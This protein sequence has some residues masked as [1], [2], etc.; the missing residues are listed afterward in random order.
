[1]VYTI[2]INNLDNLLWSDDLKYC[3]YPQLSPEIII[4]FANL[5]P[6]MSYCLF[7]FKQGDDKLFVREMSLIAFYDSSSGLG[8]V[9]YGSIG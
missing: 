2:R 8:C 4:V 7:V 3:G 1:M 5:P 9:R 6:H